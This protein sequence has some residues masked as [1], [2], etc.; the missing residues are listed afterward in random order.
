M[1]E[2]KSYRAMIKIDQQ[3]YAGQRPFWLKVGMAWEIEETGQINLE[4]ASL[5]LNPMHW[6]GTIALFPND[7]DDDDRRERD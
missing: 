3:R 5:P 6:E 4:L 1:A 2:R 7:R